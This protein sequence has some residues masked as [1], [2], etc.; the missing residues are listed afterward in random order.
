[1]CASNSSSAGYSQRLKTGAAGAAS[2]DAAGRVGFIGE[3][4]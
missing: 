2:V 3:A 1:M 4:W